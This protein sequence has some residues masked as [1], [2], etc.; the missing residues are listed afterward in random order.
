MWCIAINSTS[1]HKG[2]AGRETVHRRA[3]RSNSGLPFIAR[4]ERRAP[5]D[6]AVSLMYKFLRT[7]PRS[8]RHNLL[9]MIMIAC[10]LAGMML[11]SGCGRKAL[12]FQNIDITRSTHFGP[13][14]ALADV[15]GQ[16]RSIADYKGKVVV[17]VFGYTHCPDV[18]PTT[19][20]ELSQAMQ[21]LVPEDAKRVQILFVTVDPQRDKAPI[22]SQ[23]AAA[24]YP[25]FAALRP[26]NEDQLKKVA[27]DFDVFYEKVPGK[28]ADDYTMNHTAASFVFDPT[29]KLRLY[30]RDGQGA[31]PWVHDLKLLLD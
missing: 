30:V 12:V 6:I 7:N 24:F 27:K 29:G 3:A 2:R 25:S 19:M 5:H 9:A 26:A 1:L 4:A 14:F 16:A 8:A 10:S 11:M 20:A 31:A 28:T 13:D 17:L 23:Y 18:C 22:V 21:Q 15:D